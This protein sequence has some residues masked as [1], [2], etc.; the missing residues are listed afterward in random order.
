MRTL[1]TFVLLV[2]TFHYSTGQFNC[3]ENIVLHCNDIVM[4]STIDGIDQEQNYCN[5]DV[6]EQGGNEQIFNLHVPYFTSI[7]FTLEI[8]P[9]P[10][11]NLN[12]IIL[13]ADCNVD[14]CIAAEI[15]VTPGDEDFTIE[16]LAGNY[17]VVVDGEYFGGAPANSDFTLGVECFDVI[18]TIPCAN[19]T[20]PILDCGDSVVG[21]LGIIAGIVQ[22]NLSSYCGTNNQH[23]FE[24]HYIFY[25]NIWTELEIQATS[26]DFDVNVFLLN[27]CD[28]NDCVSGFNGNTTGNELASVII[29][30]GNYTI[31]V[32]GS[33]LEALTPEGNY[34]LTLN[35]LNQELD[36]SSPIFMECNASYSG[37]TEDI[38][39]IQNNTTS[40]CGKNGYIGYEDTYEIVIEEEI[41]VNFVLTLDSGSGNHDIYITKDCD[42]QDCV[43]DEFGQIDYGATPGDED[44]N[45]LFQ[46][47]VYFVHVDTEDGFGTYTLTLS[48]SEELDC[49]KAL[50]IEC[51]DVV[52][53]KTEMLSVGQTNVMDYCQSGFGDEI[54]YEQIYKLELTVP[55]LVDIKAF[56]LTGGLNID[57]FI[58]TDCSDRTSCLLGDTGGEIAGYN[59]GDEDFS[60]YLESGTYYIIVDS[61]DSRGAFQLS[62]GC[63]ILDCSNIETLV[64]NTLTFRNSSGSNY[65]NSVTQFT[66]V[67]EAM[68]IPTPGNEIV[69]DLTENLGVSNVGVVQTYPVSYAQPVADIDLILLRSPCEVEDSICTMG[70][71]FGD[72]S[73]SIGVNYNSGMK[74]EYVIDSKANGGGEFFLLTWFTEAATNYQGALLNGSDNDARLVDFSV[75]CN[76]ISVPGTNSGYNILTNDFVAAIKNENIPFTYNTS[77]NSCDAVDHLVIVFVDHNEDGNFED[78]EL[79]F[80]SRDANFNGNIKFSQPPHTPGIK[81]MRIIY[82]SSDVNNIVNRLRPYDLGNV[83]Y[84]LY[85]NAVDLPIHF[86]SHNSMPT[87]VSHGCGPWMEEIVLNG[88]IHQ[89]ANDYGYG[90][91]TN[92]CLDVKQGNNNFSMQPFAQSTQPEQTGFY[93]IWIDINKDDIY[94]TDELVFNDPVFDG[95]HNFNADYTELGKTTMRVQYLSPCGTPG[96]TY[97]NPNPCE[98]YF[99]GEVQDYAVLLDGELST[100]TIET[101]MPKLY[102]NPVKDILNIDLSETNYEKYAVE[103]LNTEGKSIVRK[104]FNESKFTLDTGTLEKGVYFISIKTEERVFSEL[105]FKS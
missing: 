36:C 55:R 65:Q 45:F 90:D 61:R 20:G 39:S 42:D 66:C 74:R 100:E 35:C 28:P 3:S 33:T 37:T 58:L 43:P 32:D 14:E 6:F 11:F 50:T 17:F 84:E 53:N 91:Y 75:N 86:F 44:F 16:L 92:V 49:S 89:S 93:R 56:A 105:F 73:E 68:V 8:T 96:C 24:D 71:Q 64:P 101:I 82:M 2:S 22:N 27:S 94:Q 31:I 78:T 40:W 9:N 80:F 30:P 104:E 83:S 57:V 102:P 13:S 5:F 69:Y 34:T 95:P 1:L 15:G 47:G 70:Q 10:D 103:I 81:T 41:L 62:I 99:E 26:S 85:G 29:P 63:N 21:S 38:G 87:C 51:G 7:N 23:A 12:I 46:P 72:E 52:S 19:S 60:V 76:P 18:E 67:N 54:G 88:Q 79:E 97:P 48:C 98:R 25:N 59:S 77:C 4:E